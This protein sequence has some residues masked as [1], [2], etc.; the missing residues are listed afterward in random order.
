M[1]A[2]L[3]I[4][5]ASRTIARIIST[6]MLLLGIPY[7]L[8]VGF[9]LISGE[10]ANLA[11]YL[12]LLFLVGLL[13]G[14]LIAWWKEGLGA[15]ITLI[16]LVGSFFLGGGIL[17]GV[18]VRQGFSLL[19]GPLNLLFALLIP[20]Y[21][22][23]HSPSAKWVPIISWAMPIAA[24]LLFFVSWSIRQRF[25]QLMHQGESS[26]ESEEKIKKEL[27]ELLVEG[28]ENLEIADRLQISPVHAS[29]LTA[30]LFEE[31]GVENRVE[32]LEKVKTMASSSGSK[33]DE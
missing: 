28:F 12:Y 15:T 21:H 6:L 26:S 27:L 11:I 19:A 17:P 7:L 29:L 2:N 8:F 31:Y 22:L 9:Q 18:G 32:L 16:T 13:T 23:D 20:G 5:N 25:P 33:I 10:S 24:V 4:A 1:K 14:M 30:S 3:F